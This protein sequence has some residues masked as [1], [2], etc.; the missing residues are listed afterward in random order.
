[1]S[2]LEILVGSNG[3]GKSALFEFLK[4]LRDSTYQEIPPE[5]IAGS[6]GQE[7]FHIPGG[8]R[9]GWSIDID[10]GERNSIAFDAHAL[11]LLICF[12]LLPNLP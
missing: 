11:S 6:I 3:S 9:F 8:E 10:L 4:F 1:V 12:L 7:I 5:I 2:P